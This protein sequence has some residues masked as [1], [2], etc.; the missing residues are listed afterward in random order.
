M[1]GKTAEEKAELQRQPS[2]MTSTEASEVEGAKRFLPFSTGPRGCLGQ[3]LG[4]MMHDAAIAHLYAH[5]HMV[6]AERVRNFFPLKP[7]CL[8]SA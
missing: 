3:S 4:R 2:Y 6:L 5:F 7:S 8:L 1:Q